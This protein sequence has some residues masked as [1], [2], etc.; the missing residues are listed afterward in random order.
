MNR[1]PVAGGRPARAERLD[2]QG[3][4]IDYRLDRRGEHAD[5]RLDRRGARYGRRH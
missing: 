5:Q 4:R 1:V 3:D 2:T